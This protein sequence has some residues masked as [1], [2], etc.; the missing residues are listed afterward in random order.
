MAE[1]NAAQVAAARAAFYERGEDVASWAR[2]RGF[3]PASVY[4]L[5]AGHSKARRGEAHLIA[6]ALGLKPRDAIQAQSGEVGA[7]T[8]PGPPPGN[9][10]SLRKA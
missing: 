2:S 3:R 6:V 1:I 8:Q 4:R 10:P 7:H 5:L 9:N